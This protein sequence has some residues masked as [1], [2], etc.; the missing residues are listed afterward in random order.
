MLSPDSRTVAFELLRPPAGYDLDFAL[1]TTYTLNLEAMLALPLSL[2]ASADNGIEELLTNPLLLLEAL[3][4]AG[5]RI[6]VFVDRAGIAVPRQK[7]ELYAMLEPG[8]HPVR[9]PGGGV[10]HPKVWVLRFIAEDGP[11]LIRVALLSRNL[12]FDRSWDI[13]LAS[14]AEPRSGQG[15]AGSSP[16]AE[17][18][19]C[20]PELCVEQMDPSLSDRVLTLANEVLRTHFPAPVGFSPDPLKFH[21][22]GMAGGHTG[23]S[24]LRPIS[25]GRDVL[26]VAPFVGSTA[27]NEVASMGAG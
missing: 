12:T 25:G 20:L 23:G 4:R 14:E 27:L 11:P 3:R 8:I 22:L 16:L 6:H 21:V 17:F 5:E 10:F 24:F 26:A 13:A 15:I 1:L 7:R 19:R 2:V 18:I 9:A